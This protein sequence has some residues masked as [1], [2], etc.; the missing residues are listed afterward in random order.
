MSFRDGS[1]CCVQI[2]WILNVERLFT[3]EFDWECWLSKKIVA[4][5]GRNYALSCCC[6]F[7]VE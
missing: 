5:S 1:N 2:D 4:I 6:Y 7:G 3:A